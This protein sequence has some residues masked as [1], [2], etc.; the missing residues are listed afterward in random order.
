[1]LLSVIDIIMSF[2][3]KLRPPN[4]NSYCNC[5]ANIPDNSKILGK[6]GFCDEQT[7]TTVIIGWDKPPQE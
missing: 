4:V 2:I 5:D 1:M 6:R 3:G 7:I